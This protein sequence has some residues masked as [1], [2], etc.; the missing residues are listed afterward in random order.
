MPSRKAIELMCPSPTA[1]RLMTN[2]T[3]PP[4]MPLWSGWGTIEGFIS[5][6]AA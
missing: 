6:A 2:L 1:R 4:E 3:D 5:A